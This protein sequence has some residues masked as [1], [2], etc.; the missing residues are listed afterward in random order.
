[1]K[2]EKIYED[3]NLQMVSG[4]KMAALSYNL[5]SSALRFVHGRA[6]GGAASSDG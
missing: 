3:E 6:R 2:K 1:M 4:Q 5:A